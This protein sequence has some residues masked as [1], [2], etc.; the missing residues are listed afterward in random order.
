L[1]KFS[2][3][4]FLAKLVEFNL[5]F[6]LIEFL[7]YFGDKMMKISQKTADTHQEKGKSFW[8]P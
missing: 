2:L 7:N 6:F 3:N 8:K 4:I 1:D 5:N